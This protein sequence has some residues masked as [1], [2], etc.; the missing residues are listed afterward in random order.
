[1]SPQ[2]FRVV[3]GCAL[4]IA[5]V[6]LAP[7]DGQVTVRVSGPTG[8][9]IYVSPSVVAEYV[10]AAGEGDLQRVEL[11]ALLRGQPGWFRG[12]GGGS[13][14]RSGGNTYTSLRRFGD[15]SLDVHVSYADRT[16]SVLGHHLDLRQA[17]VILLDNVDTSPSVAGTL[18]VEAWV[19]GTANGGAKLLPLLGL[20]QLRPFLRCEAG[21]GIVRPPDHDACAALAGGSR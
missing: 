2:G 12:I 4:L 7:L 20:P 18:L 6:A 13:S 9:S 17:N 21:G 1:M 15:S 11:L 14:S 19:S 10:V 8:G 16:A 3:L 5:L